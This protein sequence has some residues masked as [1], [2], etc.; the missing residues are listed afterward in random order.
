MKTMNIISLYDQGFSRFLI[1]GAVSSREDLLY[2]NNWRSGVPLLPSPSPRR[3]TTPVF[4]QLRLKTALTLWSERIAG[5][6]FVF[7]LLCTTMLS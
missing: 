4:T 6:I 7:V 5:G 3:S 2:K 1:A